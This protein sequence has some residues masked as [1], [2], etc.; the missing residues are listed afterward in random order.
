MRKK[1]NPLQVNIVAAK[2]IPYKTEPKFKP[3][4]CVTKFVD[5]SSFKTPELPQQPNCRFN[6][7]HV[8]LLGRSDPVQVREMLASKLLQVE[9]HDCDEFTNDET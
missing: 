2:D 6:A 9:L 4:F 5:G 3:V 8:W 7:K 1:C